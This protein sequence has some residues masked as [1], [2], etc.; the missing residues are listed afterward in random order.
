MGAKERK[1]GYEDYGISAEELKNIFDTIRKN[2]D[3]QALFLECCREVAPS[4]TGDL[5]YSIV[6][7]VSYEDIKMVKNVLY[8]E[9][10]FYGYRRKAIAM[11]YEKY[12]K[13]NNTV[14]ILDGQLKFDE[15]EI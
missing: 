6:E 7:H 8:Y 11:F 14:Q 3:A 9:N 1:T 2:A 13:K 15:I 5:W 12:K 4:I 10:D